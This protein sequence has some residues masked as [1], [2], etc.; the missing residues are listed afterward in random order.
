MTLLFYRVLT[1]RL[2]DVI[3]STVRERGLMPRY[4]LNIVYEYD[5]HPEDY[6]GEFTDFYTPRDAYLQES[7]PENVK[8]MLRYIADTGEYEY[9]LTEVGGN[10]TTAVDKIKALLKSHLS[11]ETRR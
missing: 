10:Q 8:H 11:Q 9:T 1:A 7:D 4:R 6:L 5:S 2:E 3:L